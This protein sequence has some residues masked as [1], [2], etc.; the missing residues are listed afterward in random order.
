[1]NLLEPLI[2]RKFGHQEIY[3]ISVLICKIILEL[4]EQAVC[5]VVALFVPFAQSRRLSS[6]FDFSLT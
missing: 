3:F 5:F 1:M 6:V 4:K 2:T